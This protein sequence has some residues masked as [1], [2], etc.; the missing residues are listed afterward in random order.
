MVFQ[1]EKSNVAGEWWKK[2]RFKRKELR[3]ALTRKGEVSRE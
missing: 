3:E 2:E 1:Q